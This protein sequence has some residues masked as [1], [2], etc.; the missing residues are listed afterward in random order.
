MVLRSLIL[1]LTLFQAKIDGIGYG[2][3]KVTSIPKIL[4]FYDII[5]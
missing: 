2:V 1:L 4:W 5:Y 3:Y